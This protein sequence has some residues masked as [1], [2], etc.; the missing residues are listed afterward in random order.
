MAVTLFTCPCK[1]PA[2]LLQPC[3][4]PTGIIMEHFPG[5]DLQ[6]YLVAKGGRLPEPICRVI[7]QQ[8]MLALEFV[9]TKGKVLRDIKLESLSCR[10]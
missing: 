7:F 6:S 9:H 4:A 10:V 5:Q 2:P 3:I 8:C 1:H